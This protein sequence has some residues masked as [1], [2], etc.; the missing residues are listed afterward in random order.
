MSNQIYPIYRILPG[1][2][3]VSEAVRQAHAAGAGLWLTGR[4]QVIVA[5]IGRPGWRRLPISTPETTPC[6]A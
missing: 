4:G 2:T 5:P 1:K 6:A 3:R